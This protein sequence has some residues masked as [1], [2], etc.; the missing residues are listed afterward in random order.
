MRDILM[1]ICNRNVISRMKTRGT[2]L[3]VDIRGYYYFKTL[4]RMIAKVP[5]RRYG[6]GYDTVCMVFSNR[7]CLVVYFQLY[8]YQALSS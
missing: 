2:H 3:R 8:I 4:Y 5:V 6:V 7:C 1:V